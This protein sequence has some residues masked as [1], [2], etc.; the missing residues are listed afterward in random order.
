MEKAE[1]LVEQI[2]TDIDEYEERMREFM[3]RN[4][5]I[6][7]QIE[8]ISKDDGDAETQRTPNN[9]WRAF[10][11]NPALKPNYLD[12][13]ASYL[14]TTHFC[15]L[16]KSYIM[17]G[18]QGNPRGSAIHI[19]LQP[20][21]EPTWWTSL[22]KQGV[23]QNKS[24]QQIVDIIMAESDARNPLHSRRM[25]LLRVKKT[26]SHSDFLFNLE[27]IGALIDIQS[28]TLEA[29]IMHLFLE[30]SDQTMAKTCQE[31]LAKNQGE[32]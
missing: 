29:L 22:G 11:P 23:T 15:E 25:N 1:D 31:I 10:K 13:E 5:E 3:T 9:E 19:H 4:D 8:T 12:K 26:G 14:D 17:D 24:L 20:L 21:V 27:E 30:Q 28:L 32:T 6:I 2:K 18:F 16:F 7:F